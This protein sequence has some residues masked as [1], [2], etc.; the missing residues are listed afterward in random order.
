MGL[1]IGCSGGQFRLK[2]VLGCEQKMSIKFQWMAERKPA[3]PQ[4]LRVISLTL[5]AVSGCTL[6][7]AAILALTTL[8]LQR[9][10]VR[11]IGTVDAL[12]EVHDDQQRSTTYA[13]VFSFTTEDGRTHSIVSH[14][15]SSTANYAVGDRVP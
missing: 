15:S 5:L 1:G 10:G 4:A 11:I 13:P 2:C 12:S 9:N 6:L 8:Q 14:I 3:S 7:L